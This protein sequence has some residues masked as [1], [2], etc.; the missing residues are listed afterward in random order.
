MQKVLCG[1]CLEPFTPSDPPL[2]CEACGLVV[3]APCYGYPAFP[4]PGRSVPSVSQHVH[5]TNENPQKRHRKVHRSPLVDQTPI[6]GGS[7]TKPAWLG[8][9]W[10]CAVCWDTRR[11]TAEPS[12]VDAVFPDNY[13]DARTENNCDLEFSSSPVDSRKKRDPST[14]VGPGV[15]THGESPRCLA[16]P[17]FQCVLCPIR[18]YRLAMKPIIEANALN[19]ASELP[20]V[21]RYV[22]V[23]CALA[24]PRLEPTEPWE[25]LDAFRRCQHAVKS[26]DR[27]SLGKETST[28]EG[29]ALSA[30]TPQHVSRQ[31]LDETPNHDSCLSKQCTLC[32]TAG[33][34][35]FCCWVPL[36]KNSEPDDD[37]HVPCPVVFHP[38]CALL[39]GWWRPEPRFVSRGRLRVSC[40]RHAIFEQRT[41]VPWMRGYPSTPKPGDEHHLAAFRDLVES[42][43]V[44]A[45]SSMDTRTLLHSIQVHMLPQP[46]ACLQAA[47]TESSTSPLTSE[48]QS[49]IRKV[50]LPYTDQ[51]Q[52]AIILQIAEDLGLEP[53]ITLRF[54]ASHMKTPELLQ[55][56]LLDPAVLALHASDATSSSSTST[57]SQSRQERPVRA[58][59]SPE[60]LM[61]PAPL[62]DMY[63]RI[64]A[65]LYHWEPREPFPQHC[66]WVRTLQRPLYSEA[67]LLLERVRPEQ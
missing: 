42:L 53:R 12:S 44:P 39:A 3:H 28:A 61:T 38:M 13:Q 7:C 65:R 16:E 40:P 26:E 57:A 62:E 35:R 37:H 55:W 51:M 6:T 64:W 23:I 19:A 27:A 15:G 31:V 50:L 32:E 34:L 22:H 59:Q 52:V 56:L 11:S 45:A 67:Q 46:F 43:Y 30:H 1:V 48:T 25:C 8:L 2:T 41:P 18:D 14:A 29:I 24:D 4:F 49:R 60:T 66:G 5:P 10:N 47:M 36:Q 54:L 17:P 58:H 33:G 63:L 21:E 20:H 9:A